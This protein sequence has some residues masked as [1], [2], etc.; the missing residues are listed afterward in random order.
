[1]ASYRPPP[2]V[3]E[4]SI[5]AVNGLSITLQAF[6][7][8]VSAAA[9]FEKVMIVEAEAQLLSEYPMK[10]P[11]VVQYRAAHSWLPT[12]PVVLPGRGLFVDLD[13]AIEKVGRFQDYS[14][15]KNNIA[16]KMDPTSA[17]SSVTNPS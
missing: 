12:V 14:M 7:P 9:L 3:F 17:A 5:L 13:A 8:L 2:A 15:A 11:R 16:Q 10:H 1:M 4:V 6:S